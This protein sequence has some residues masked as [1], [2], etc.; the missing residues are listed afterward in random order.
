MQ[1]KLPLKQLQCRGCGAEKMHIVTAHRIFAHL[2]DDA[3]FID[4]NIV[5]HFA[6]IV[7]LACTCA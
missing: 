1:I 2:T 6:I 3:I 5:A 4:Y 7:K